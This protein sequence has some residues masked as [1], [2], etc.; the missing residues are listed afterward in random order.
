MI[1][2]RKMAEEAAALLD[3]HFG[4]LSEAAVNMNYRARA[5][6]AHPDSPTG[7]AEAFV[8]VDRAKHVL[9]AWLERTPERPTVGAGTVCSRCAGKG[10]VELHRGFR[11]MRAVCL[12]C[13]GSGDM[14]TEHEKGE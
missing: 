11:T 5:K 6:A 9:L 3:V 12:A 7:S 8:A 10:F 1:V 2:S 14:E 4:T 13:R